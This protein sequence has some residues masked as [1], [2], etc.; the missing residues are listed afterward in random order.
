MEDLMTKLF[1]LFLAIV[2]VCD[3][4]GQEKVTL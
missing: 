4:L 3:M 1:T 2:I